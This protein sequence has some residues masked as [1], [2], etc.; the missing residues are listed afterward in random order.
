MTNEE[1]LRNRQQQLE[2]LSTMLDLKELL[3]E[4][5]SLTNFR[6]MEITLEDYV[7]T[8]RKRSL[9]SHSDEIGLSLTGTPRIP[10]SSVKPTFGFQYPR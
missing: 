8:V 9:P 3:T 7:I 10:G 2:V 6:T 1:K 5:D 4:L